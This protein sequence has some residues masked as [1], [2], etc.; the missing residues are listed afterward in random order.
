MLLDCHAHIRHFMQLG[1]TLPDSEGIPPQKL[2]NAA[3]SVARFFDQDLPLHQADEDQSLFSRLHAPP[4]CELVRVA[5]ETMVEQHKAIN[6]VIAEFLPLCD[7]LARH[8]ERLLSIS[9]R[10]GDVSQA[11]Q[12]VFAAH[13][14]LEET[15]IFPVLAEM[16]P[17]E[18]NEISR[19]M[20]DRRRLALGTIHLVR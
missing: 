17:T 2:A 9:R 18:L 5:V 3:N 12:Q 11:L 14:I 1:R 13:L 10:L 6:E 15:V 20:H 7:T 19:E 4:Q 16:S 8:P